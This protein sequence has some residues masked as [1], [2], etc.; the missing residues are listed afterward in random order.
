MK[1]IKETLFKGTCALALGLLPGFAFAQNAGDVIS[2]VISDSE[3]P[4][5]MVNVVEVDAT[6]RIVSH[7][8][9]DINGEWSFRLGSPKNKLQVSYIGYET[10]SLAI[11]KTYFDITMKDMAEIEEVVIKA[12][13]VTESSGLAIPEREISGA[14]QRISMEEF[15]GL[16]IT[17]VDEALQGRISGLDIV[18][19]SG[20][21]GSGSSMHLRGTSTITGNT[22]PLIVVDGN[23]WHNDFNQEIDYASANDEKFAELL[24]V[25]PEDISSITVL[26]DAA[27]T[28][29]WGTQ[30]SNGVIEIKTKRGSRGKTRTT[31]SLRMNGTWQPE[32]IKLMNG[33]QYTMFLKE[34]YFNPELSDDAADIDVLNYS[35]SFSEYNM[36]NDNTDWAKLVKKFGLQQSHNLS[37]SGGGEKANFRVAAGFD[38]QNGSIIAQK[39]NRFTTRVALDYFV[40]DRIKVVTNFSM[41]YTKNYQN[42]D[43]LL[44]LAL[45][46]MPNLSPYYEDADG[47]DTDIYYHM[48]SQDTGNGINYQVNPL[49]S[50]YLAQ[51]INTQL[52]I[53]PE[54]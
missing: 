50:A 19:N 32:G 24:N 42:A 44:S 20:D 51:N 46:R 29:I 47:N 49:A 5:M 34:A 14:S 41:T 54:F 1:K 45:E 23:V 6:G 27:A 25:N 33:D 28:A 53:Q 16:G 21:L 22:N 15:E 18:F 38:H 36:Y 37:I 26:K 11:N 39:L 48:R 4:M 10:V 43:G 3:G 35:P 52:S 17:T 2:G 31:Y 12:D 40:S 13:R 7:A 9:T 30:G 8:I